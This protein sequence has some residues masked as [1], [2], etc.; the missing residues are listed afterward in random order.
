MSKKR[1]HHSVGQIVKKLRDTK[2]MLSAG[3]T[4]A[5]VVQVLGVGEQT[6]SWTRTPE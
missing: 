4:V 6:Y 2:T 1:Q 5:K 3:K